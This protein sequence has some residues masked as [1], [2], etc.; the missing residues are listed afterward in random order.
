MED[1]ETPQVPSLLLSEP[2]AL[3]P[4]PNPCLRFPKTEEAIGELKRQ[5]DEIVSLKARVLQ[6]KR[7]ERQNREFNGK[8]ISFSNIWGKASLQISAFC[9]EKNYDEALK[10]ASS[11]PLRR[12]ALSFES[13]KGSGH[14]PSMAYLP[15]DFSFLC[16]KGKSPRK[17]R[18]GRGGKAL[19]AMPL[20]P[21]R[22]RRD[23]RGGRID[24]FGERVFVFRLLQLARK[25]RFGG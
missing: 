22:P 23:E 1:I 17:H 13:R 25:R 7:K 20:P 9:H 16:R 24:R 10:I 15:I 11:L 21:R 19:P 3:P 2:E 18:Q 5:N 4:F 6:A 8:I 14:H 12:I